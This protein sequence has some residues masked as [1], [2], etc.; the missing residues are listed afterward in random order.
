M[1]NKTCADSVWDAGGWHRYPCPN[2]ARYGDYCGLHSPEKKAA[3]RVKRGPTKYER[4][5]AMRDEYRAA[6]DAVLR[7]ARAI[8]ATRRGPLYEALRVFDEVTQR[9]PPVNR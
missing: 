3:R 5:C 2:R 9:V 1:S 4:E 6:L 8:V 7:E